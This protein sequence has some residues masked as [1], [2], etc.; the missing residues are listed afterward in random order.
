MDN[1][2]TVLN[3]IKWNF[4]PEYSDEVL[5]GMNLKSTFKLIKRLD[6]LPLDSCKIRFSSNE[7]AFRP[8]VLNRSFK[9]KC[10]LNFDTISQLYKEEIKFFILYLIWSEKNK[11]QS[12][13]KK[14][15][16]LKKFTNYLESIYISSLDIVTLETIEYFFEHNIK[17]FSIE[18]II[19]YKNTLIEFYEF[20]SLNYN[21]IEYNNIYKYLKTRNNALYIA[22][23][24]S[25]KWDTIP[26][27]YFNNLL[28]CLYNV[29]IDENEP[30]DLRGIAAEIIL[31]S[32]TGLRQGD[33]TDCTVDAL[34]SFSI[35]S[36]NKKI[37]ALRYFTCKSESGNGNKKEIY[38]IITDLAFEAFSVLKH[39]YFK[40]RKKHNTNLLYVPIK[41]KSL[42]VS[43]NTLDKNLTRFLLTYSD[44]FNCI[45]IQHKYPRLKHAS[46]KWWIEQ[47]N[48][49]KE[50]LSKFKLTDVVV[51]PRP[52]QF[53][54]YLCNKLYEQGVELLFIKTH[55]AHLSKEM[56]VY[57]MRPKED[58]EENKEYAEAIMKEIV[59]GDTKLLGTKS[60][61]LI[62]KINKF[63]DNSKL[64]ISEN[65][66]DIVSQLVKTFPVRAKSGGVC[67]KSGLV[68]ECKHNNITDE[69]FCAYGICEN[70]FHLYYMADITYEN[71]KTLLKTIDYNKSK[72]FTK[73]VEKET[74]KIK[75]IVTNTFLPELDELKEQL[76]LKGKDEILKIH[77]NLSYLIDNLD[78]IYK[79]IKKW[80]A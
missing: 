25:S 46:L 33:L 9:R 7:W 49:P 77:E 79:E 14:L 61:T 1:N 65:L 39:I 78:D 26:E 52:H 80:T 19:S 57:Y 58:L 37:Y 8:I 24:E 35:S 48:A 34:E 56:T 71:Y 21:R 64:N 70:S 50:V 27:D 68:R 38:T 60:N 11:L 75:C 69:I 5:K 66:E 42:P 28:I 43:E 16:Q 20:H 74:N 53:R 63:I 62:S 13:N 23:R 47:K 15:G 2:S 22:K 40:S 10:I 31:L 44:R 4:T 41:C 32:Q 36:T 3:D 6:Y 12:I 29:M 30:I 67:I 55:M 73:A 18:T 72:G 17:N 76:V 59:S 54:V 45:N 51:L